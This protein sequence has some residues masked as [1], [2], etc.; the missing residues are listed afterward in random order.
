M[1]LIAYGAMGLGF[2][3]EMEL[4][5][6]GFNG[7]LEGDGDPIVGSFEEDGED[8]GV[9]T[10]SLTFSSATVVSRSVRT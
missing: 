5:A 8:V 4:M 1:V 7:N 2:K 9:M 6:S 10:A 3:G